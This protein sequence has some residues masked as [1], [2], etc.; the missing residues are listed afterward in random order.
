MT[1]YGVDISGYQ[2]GFDFAANVAACPFIL[3]KQTEGLIWPEVNSSSADTL[4][5]LRHLA[6]L[7]GYEY[8]GLYHFA[9]P[10]HGRTGRDEAEH[11]IRFVGTLHLN[12]GVC[13]D[14]EVN[15]GLSFEELEDFALA[16]IDRIEEEWPSLAGNVCLYSGPDF[17]AHMSTDR[18]VTRCPLWLS[19]WG[20]NNG[21][22][23]AGAIDM[24]R[25]KT[26]AF[27]QFTSKGRVPGWD[28]DI[29][30][31]R[32]DGDVITL[33]HLSVGSG[34]VIDPPVPP[35]PVVIQPP[36]VPEGWPGETL[37]RGSSGIRVTQIQAR[38]S[39][40]GWRIGIDGNFGRETDTVV[41]KF[42]EE[43]NLVVDGIVGEMTWDA[44]YAFFDG[45][46]VMPLPIEVPPPLPPAPPS[47]GGILH[48]DPVGQ[49]QA[50]GFDGNAGLDS[51]TE[52]QRAFAW[53]PLVVDGIAG[54]HTARAVQM[55]IENGNK[56]SEHFAIR[57]LACRHCWRI[58]FLRETLEC[59]ELVRAEVGPYSPISAYRCPAHNA[60]IGGAPN[61]QHPMGAA[62]DLDILLT[63][64]QR[65]RFSGMG[66][67]FE[68]CL[69]GDRRDASGNNTTGATQSNPTNWSYC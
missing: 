17:L 6:Q 61:G 36:F 8:V 27:W 26:Y 42:Q 67:C 46:D 30:V 10:Q 41:R 50:W 7:V 44:M 23:H 39:R 40:R 59:M 49:C 29:D 2:T 18:L 24:D 33:S 65:V 34:H 63:L 31:N 68:R 58:R 16:F 52:F 22:E 66:I 20:A 38:L 62:V 56:L 37:R 64:A 11:F 32:F 60:N 47:N 45:V 51:V 57:E 28:G 35:P 55:V 5:N 12:E 1:I 14:L 43:K 13:L 48:A 3:I 21:Q 53:W 19:A 69:H 25:W 54:T 4:I 15:N 9:R